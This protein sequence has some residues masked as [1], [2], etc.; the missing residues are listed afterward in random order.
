[1]P[2]QDAQDRLDALIERAVD[3]TMLNGVVAAMAASQLACPE[4]WAA[5]ARFLADLNRLETL[6]GVSAA[7]VEQAAAGILALADQGD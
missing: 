3:L 7:E 2:E 1:M 6:P 4:A 5:R